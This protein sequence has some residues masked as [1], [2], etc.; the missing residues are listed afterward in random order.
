MSIDLMNA[1]EYWGAQRSTD[2]S[3]IK[4]FSAGV[5]GDG[6]NLHLQSQGLLLLCSPHLCVSALVTLNDTGAKLTFL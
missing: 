4:V 6:Y 2:K 3:N 1:Y 5:A